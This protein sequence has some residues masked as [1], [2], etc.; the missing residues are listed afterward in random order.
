MVFFWEPYFTRH[1]KFITSLQIVIFYFFYHVLYHQCN[2]TT[3]LF[4]RAGSLFSTWLTSSAE[5]SL[6]VSWPFWKWQQLFG[7]M[8][9]TYFYTG[10]TN[11]VVT[12]EELDNCKIYRKMDLHFLD[13]F[14]DSTVTMK[15]RYRFLILR[16]KQKFDMFSF[17]TKKGNKM[18][19]WNF[20]V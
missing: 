10:W 19:F 11:L 3:T 1:T 7:G 18:F 17:S 5:L 12:Y 9:R 16:Y 6:Y 13:L 15:I 4:Y 2:I 14:M 8:V 20:W